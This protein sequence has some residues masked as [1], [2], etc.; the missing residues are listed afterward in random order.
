MTPILK[1]SEYHA[2]R[3]ISLTILMLVVNS[4]RLA[5]ENDAA[6]LLQRAV[7][8]LYADPKEASAL[9]NRA[10]KLCDMS[11]PDSVC[12]EA[13]ILYANAEQ[14]LGNFDLSIKT[15]FDAEQMTDST[16]LHTF[17][18]IFVLQGR[19]FSKLGDYARANKLNDRATAIFK[20]LGDSAWVAKCYTERGVTLLNTDEFILA[21]HFFRKSLDISRKLKNL[22]A[23]ARNLNNMCLYPGDSDEKLKIIEEAITINKHLDSK[24]ALGENYN[25]KGKQLCYA[26]K[27]REALAALEIANRYIDEIGARELL[28]DNYEYTAMA[29][30]AAG[31]FKAAY[32]NMEKM[33]VLVSELQRHNSQ[34]NTDLDITRK[35]FENQKLAAEKQEKDYE[36]RILHRNLW[37]LIGGV[38]MIAVCC[39]FYYLWYKHKKN[40]ELIQANQDLHLAE[41]EVDSL[42]MRQQQL[43]LEN[44]QNLLSESR[45]ELTGFAA[46][47]K[48]RN[49]M[50]E[51]IRDML[52][53][54]YK[55]PHDEMVPH[56]KKISAFISSYA[57]HDDTSKTLLLKAEELNKDFMNNLLQKHP[58]LTKGERNLAL[59]IRGGMSTKEISML[60]GLET[61]TINMN[62]YR[63]RKA[64]GIPQ[65]ADLHDYLTSL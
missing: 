49:E 13:S 19:V 25:N 53:E 9:A 38:M 23:I 11:K 8:H 65:D 28:C 41:K 36:I 2:F 58:N 48:S 46:F 45:Q 54:G 6:T 20:S 18:R 30:A 52:K 7:T 31:N 43:E 24:W 44:T 10:L 33:T 39:L 51:K 14:L 47:L 50:M 29:N 35:R 59:L 61:K 34:R 17:A 4:Q 32:E 3:C 1:L 42:K 37:I 26:N 63:L 12:R 21:E 22:E 64:L 62:R 16:D 5:A 60:L 15:L 40:L 57:S 56:L 27:P 55:L